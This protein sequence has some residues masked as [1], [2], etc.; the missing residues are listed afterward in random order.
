[1]YYID[2]SAGIEYTDENGRD[3]T[4]TAN[5]LDNVDGVI[6]KSFSGTLYDTGTSDE[7][8][9]TNGAFRVNRIG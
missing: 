9:I 5:R 1:L 6:E 4:I 7:I 8:P 2:Y 3:L